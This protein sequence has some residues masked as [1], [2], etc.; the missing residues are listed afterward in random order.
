[1]LPPKRIAYQKIGYEMVFIFGALLMF[2]SAFFLRSA[3]KRLKE[4]SNTNKSSATKDV[5]GVAV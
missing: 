4:N 2:G 1:V 3:S 5:D